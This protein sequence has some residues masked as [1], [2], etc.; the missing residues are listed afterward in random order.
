M[1]SVY[2]K[3]VSGSIEE[4][5]VIPMDAA[6]SPVIK[7][8]L[9]VD[10]TRVG[11]RTDFE[12]ITLDVWTDGTIKPEDAMSQAAKILK[13]HFSVFIPER[14]NDIFNQQNYIFNDRRRWCIVVPVSYRR[15]RSRKLFQCKIFT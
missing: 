14:L 5:G 4:I 1:S 9:Q 15:H 12:K 10:N 2:E 13:D 3:P 7:A 11:Q 6:F 8:N